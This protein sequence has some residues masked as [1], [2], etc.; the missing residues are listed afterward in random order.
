MLGKLFISNGAANIVDLIFMVIE[1][2]PKPEKSEQECQLC[3]A[4]KTNFF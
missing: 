2:L 4:L 1:N 3:I